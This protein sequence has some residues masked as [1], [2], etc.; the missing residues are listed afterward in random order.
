MQIFTY[1]FLSKLIYRYGN[2]LASIFLLSI[3]YDSV[4]NLNAS[5]F[6]L[7][8]FLIALLMLYYLNK[9]YLMLYK[10]LPSRIAADSEKLVCS[11]FIFSRKELTI[12]YSN[13]ESLS[14]GI[15][16]GKNYGIMKICDGRNKVCIGFFNSLRNSRNLEKIILAKVNKELYENAAEKIKAMRK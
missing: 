15:F 8:P 5:L 12:I 14:G 9:H 11:G 10:I 6:N 2:I 3:L 7:I 13:I 1:P 4:S 16:D